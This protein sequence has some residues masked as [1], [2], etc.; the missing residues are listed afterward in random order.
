MLIEIAGLV[1]GALPLFISAAEH[2]RDSF[3]LVKRALKKKQFPQQYKD[4]LALQRTLLCLYIKAVVGKTSLLLA[5]QAELVDDFQGDAWRRPEV[6]KELS[7]ELGKASQP[8]ITL[9]T[10]I[11]RLWRSNS[12]LMVAAV[13]RQMTMSQVPYLF[14]VPAQQLTFDKVH[15]PQQLYLEA[16]TDTSESAREHIWSR[17]KFSWKHAD[18]LNLLAELKSYNSAL[19]KLGTAVNHAKP[20]ERKQQTRRANTTF[21]L[22]A[23]T[24]RLYE[25]IC[26]AC[27]CQPLK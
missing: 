23:D 19:K 7:N 24:E 13:V 10:S 17:T 26:K 6:V 14:R 18:R 8:F 27:S 3:A 11:L 12:G 22:P 9:L 20:Y 2:Y 21:R 1:L 16:V 5:T 25:V 4:E 15:K